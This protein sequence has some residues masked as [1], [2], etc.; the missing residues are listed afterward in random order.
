MNK[1]DLLLS[2]GSDPFVNTR[3]LAACLSVEGHAVFEEIQAMLDT[4]N[5]FTAFES[6]L[7]VFP[8]IDTD[9]MPSLDSWNQL[10][11]WRRRYRDCVPD[12]VVFFAHDLFGG[13]FG[14]LDQQIVRFDPECGKVS[15]YAESLVRWAELLLANYAEET[16][17]PLAHEW[18]LANGPLLP[19]QRLLP[20]Q[21]FILGGDYVLDNMTIVDARSAMENWGRLY[22]AIRD[23]PDGREVTIYGWLEPQC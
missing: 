14:A 6:A 17:W 23:V 4:K 19:E 12:S 13:Q 18:Q 21:P 3:K 11:G 22:E 15:R 10:G 5:G 20:R 16:G 2:L 9:S 7:V 1:L 8:T